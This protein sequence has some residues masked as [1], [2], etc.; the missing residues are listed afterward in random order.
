MKHGPILDYHKSRFCILHVYIGGMG[1]GVPCTGV[2]L[3]RDPR[4]RLC[5][6]NPCANLVMLC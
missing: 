5:L 2:T 4:G 3:I 1:F 6:S